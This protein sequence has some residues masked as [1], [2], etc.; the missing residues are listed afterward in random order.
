MIRKIDVFD[1]IENPI[2][3]FYNNHKIISNIIIFILL[4]VFVIASFVVLILAAVGGGV[5]INYIAD[6]YA[7]GTVS[8]DT[9]DVAKNIIIPI[10]TQSLNIISTCCF[11]VLP[12]IWLYHISRTIYKWYKKYRTLNL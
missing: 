7:N 4:F 2:I 1:K 11:I 10:I 8:K 6:G 3:N 9:Y 5:Y 12:L